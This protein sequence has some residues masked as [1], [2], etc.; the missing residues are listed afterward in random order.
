MYRTNIETNQGFGIHGLVVTTIGHGVIT[1]TQ[2][3]HAACG[4]GAIGGAAVV[5]ITKIVNRCDMGTMIF[6]SVCLL[7]DFSTY[8]VDN[9]YQ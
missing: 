5:L 1:H 4:A 8:F 6:C 2:L 7:K 3:G 9:W